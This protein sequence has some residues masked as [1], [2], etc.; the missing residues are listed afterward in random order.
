MAKNGENYNGDDLLYIVV[1]VDNTHPVPVG[2]DSEDESTGYAR[3]LLNKETN[4]IYQMELIVDGIFVSGADNL[5]EDNPVQPFHFHNQPQGGPNFFVQQLFDVDPAT[6][7]ITTAA[8]ENT[9]TG[10]SFVIDEPYAMRDPVNNPGLGVDFVIDE[11]LD[12][13]AYLGIHTNLRPIPATPIAGD[14]V[15]LSDGTINGKNL[16][17][18]DDNDVG[19]GGKKND[20]LSLGAGEDKARGKKGDDIIDGGAD[21]DRLFG[22]HGDDVMWGGDDDDLVVGGFGNDQLFGNRGDDDLRGGFDND[23]L[24][25]G[26]G[27]D[28]LVGGFGDDNLTGGSDADTFRFGMFSG[29]DVITDFEVGVDTIAFSG[30]QQVLAASLDD[31]DG[32]G[33]V[34]DTSLTLIGGDVAVLNA[35]LTGAFDLLV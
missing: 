4:E 34:D 29:S 23:D 35:D 31:L 15:A 5:L 25:G 11:I 6:G 18:G 20:L 9:D 14:M 19:I 7:E 26:Q 28:N 21:N 2:W 24:D 17:L 1:E 16:W 30:A 32:D 12:G 10:F 3:I 27:I 8:L 13:N 33:D 22:Q